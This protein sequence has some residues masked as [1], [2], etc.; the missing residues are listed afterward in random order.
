MT[1]EGY[2]DPEDYDDPIKYIINYDYSRFLSLNDT[3]HFRLNVQQNVVNTLDGTRNI[4]Y[5]TKL[6]SHDSSTLGFKSFLQFFSHYI[7]NIFYMINIST[8]EFLPQLEDW[9]LQNQLK[10]KI[11]CQFTILLFI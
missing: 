5:T 10:M 7:M 2:Y 8:I 3:N 4:F 11:S 1:I 6:S 9:T